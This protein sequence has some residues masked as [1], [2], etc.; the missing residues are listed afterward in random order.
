MALGLIA[1]ALLVGGCNDE[2]KTENAALYSENTELRDQL[3][4]TR[5]AL[6]AAETDRGR[7]Q[8]QVASLQSR[9]DEMQSQP[10]VA[11]NTGFERIEGIEVES[12][13]RGEVTV[14]VP[15]DIL[16]ASGKA[17][18]KSSAKKTLSDIAAVLKTKYGDQTV[19]V[20][21]YTDSDPIKKSK[22]EDNLQLSAARAMAVHRH[23]QSLGVD[24][25]RLYSAG[26][27]AT[28]FRASNSTP[29]GKAQNRR[30]EIVVIMN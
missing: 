24:K 4:L 25:E 22:W 20:E 16:F 10:A 12:G 28:N 2:L 26:F 19:R 14:R 11:A 1:A 29:Q 21:G 7:L 17:E 15:G 30:V 13:A 6:E 8:D 3:E 18:L 23:L 27:G 9:L 5:A